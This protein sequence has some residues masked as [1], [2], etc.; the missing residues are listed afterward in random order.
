M[1]KKFLI[2]ITSLLFA[3][4]VAS[5]NNNSGNSNS[6]FDPYNN[7]IGYQWTDSSAAILS[8]DNDIKFN[9]TSS[10]NALAMDYG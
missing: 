4:T 1:R 8:K 10:K 9:I 2:G 5:C 7:T 3:A 6:N